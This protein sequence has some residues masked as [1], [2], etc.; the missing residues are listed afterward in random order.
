MPRTSLPEFPYVPLY[1]RDFLDDDKVESMNTT[2]IG[3]Y[4]LLL[5]RSWNQEPACSLPADDHLLARY[6]RMELADWSAAKARVLSPFKRRGNRY[7][8]PRLL[9]E[10][11][12]IQRSCENKKKAGKAGANKRWP[13]SDLDSSAIASLKHKSAKRDEIRR[14]ESERESARV[15]AAAH[16]PPRPLARSPRNAMTSKRET[17]G[18]PLVRQ[19][20]EA[21]GLQPKPEDLLPGEIVRELAMRCIHPEVTAIWIQ[22]TGEAKQRAGDP[23]RSCGFFREAIGDATNAAR[24]IIERRMRSTGGDM[25]NW[26]VIEQAPGLVRFGDCVVGT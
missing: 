5:L 18:E 3:A 24:E 14:E 26:R 8:Q 23:I 7:Y 13:R 17:P 9:A 15:A 22:E 2:E 4:V 21:I 25:G 6:A 12:K 19:A 1:V 20:L 16:D 11:E 10:F